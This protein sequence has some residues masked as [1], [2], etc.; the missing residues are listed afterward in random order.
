MEDIAYFRHQSGNEK[1][2]LVFNYKNADAGIDRMFN[3]QRM[4]SETIDATFA[5]IRTNIDKELNKGRSGG[6]KKKPTK[7]AHGN[8]ESGGSSVILIEL[9][10][11]PTVEIE[12]WL[13]FIGFAEQSDTKTTLKIGERNYS[14]TF[15]DPYVSQMSLPTVILVGYNC[16]PSRF[17][18]VFA[19]RDQCSYQWFRALPTSDEQNA[20]N[21][22]WIQCDNGN[23]FFY[24]VN[25]NDFQHK[26]KVIFFLDEK[27]FLGRISM[28][29]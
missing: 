16:Y 7:N 8:M 21:V 6:K 5:R 29:K 20:A 14:A 24:N 4:V 19:E 26:L 1:F 15:N 9:L 2:E 17:E 22:S 27:Y 10:T 25:A 12:T 11:T 28:N 23:G 13:D 3:M 18:V